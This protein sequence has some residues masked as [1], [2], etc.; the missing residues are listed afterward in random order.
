MNDICP[1]GSGAETMLMRQNLY[2]YCIYTSL[3]VE[4]ATFRGTKILKSVKCITVNLYNILCKI[5]QPKSCQKLAMAMRWL[6]LIPFLIPYFS[7][8]FPSKKGIAI[9]FQVVREPLPFAYHNQSL[10]QSCKVKFNQGDIVSKMIF[11]NLTLRCLEFV[12]K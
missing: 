11:I 12:F 2:K 5:P 8:T 6:H 1:Y 3:L 9:S 10:N 7:F 4:L